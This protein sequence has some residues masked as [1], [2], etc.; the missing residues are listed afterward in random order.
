MTHR[1]WLDR[2]WIQVKKS[3]KQ[4]PQRLQS[5]GESN[6]TFRRGVPSDIGHD[7][8]KNAMCLKSKYKKLGSEIN[9]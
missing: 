6:P 1:P 5:V 8:T 9:L 2:E 4:E 3:E 7:T